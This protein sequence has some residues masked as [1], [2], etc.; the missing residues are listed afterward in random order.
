MVTM[1]IE[2]A[3]WITISSGILLGLLCTAAFD[4]TIAAS[5]AQEVG[6]T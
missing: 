3:E 1:D 4:E 5:N 6:P 2:A